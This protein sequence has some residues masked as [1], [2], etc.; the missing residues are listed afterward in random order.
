MAVGLRDTPGVSEENIRIVRTIYAEWER[1]D[2]SSVD[3]AH[4][5]I[6]FLIPGIDQRSERGIE[7]MGRA[8]AQWLR[9][10]EGFSVEGQEFFDRGDNVVVRQVF[11]GT[12]QGSGIPL[13]AAPGSAVLSL[14][15]GK[16]TRFHGT[17]TLEE[18]LEEA[19]IEP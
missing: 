12:G 4:P 13:E 15:D 9:A 7:S 10:F 17:L 18:A 5:E 11:H 1:G 8:W 14:K 6:E 3:W 19:G 16:V 2:F